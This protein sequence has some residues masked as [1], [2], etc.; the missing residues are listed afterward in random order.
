MQMDGQLDTMTGNI[1][2]IKIKNKDWRWP[3]YLK[4]NSIMKIIILI[5]KFNIPNIYDILVDIFPEN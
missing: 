5:E 2:N 3:N 4:V 1:N